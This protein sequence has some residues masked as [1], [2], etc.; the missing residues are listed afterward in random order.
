MF[1]EDLGQVEFQLAAH[2]ARPAINKSVP[3]SQHRLSSCQQTR[4]ADVAASIDHEKLNGITRARVTS[5]GGDPS[6]IPCAD[7]TYDAHWL[8]SGDDAQREALIVLFE[9]YLA[10]YPQLHPGK[11][12]PGSKKTQQA[13]RRERDR[14]YWLDALRRLQAGKPLAI[15]RPTSI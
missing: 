1:F 15:R 2:G 12:R 6:A 4:K 10:H 14:R 8:Y 11:K 3:I 9:Q 13:H 7:A 5:R